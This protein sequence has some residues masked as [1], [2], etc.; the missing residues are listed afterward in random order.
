MPPARAAAGV[1]P[2]MRSGAA[3]GARARARARAGARA[4]AAG[5]SASVLV[6]LT[7]GCGSTGVTAERVEGAFAPAFARLYVRQQQLE[8]R[9]DAPTVRAL[10]S[11]ATCTR[12]DASVPD[13]GAGSDWSCTVQ[14]LV[15]GPGTPV[16]LVYSLTVRP[17][18]CYTAEDPPVAMGRRTITTAAGK[19]VTNPVFAIDGCFATS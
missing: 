12:G 14:F 3:V 15:A 5:A 7:A 8:G 2:E 17:D 9:T 19:T 13:A 4:V 18:G 1:G 16:S 6:A 11:T 10:G